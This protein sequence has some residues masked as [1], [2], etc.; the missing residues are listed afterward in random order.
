MIHLIKSIDINNRLQN[1]SDTVLKWGNP[2]TKQSTLL[3]SKLGPLL[4]LTGSRTAA[5]HCLGG[6][7][8]RWKNAGVFF[9][10][11]YHKVHTQLLL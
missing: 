8:G 3:P 7:R 6:R 4:S 11:L 9:L 10:L 1:Y 5:Q 2:E